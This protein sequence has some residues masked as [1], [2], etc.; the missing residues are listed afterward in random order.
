MVQTEQM[1]DGGVQ[2]VDADPMDGSFVA[3][4]VR[5]A[6]A[7]APF[8]ACTGEPEGETMRIVVAARFLADLSDR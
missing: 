1:E 5:C 2:I 6:E 8:D 4:L 3:Q 7:H